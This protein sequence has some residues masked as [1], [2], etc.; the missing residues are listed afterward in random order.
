MEEVVKYVFFVARYMLY[1]KKLKQA[2]F[3]SIVVISRN[4]CPFIIHLYVNVFIR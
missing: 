3:C 4:I 1:V 2:R